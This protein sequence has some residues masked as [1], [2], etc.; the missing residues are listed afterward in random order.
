MTSIRPGIALIATL[1]L[2][3]CSTGGLDSSR[4]PYAPGPKPGALAVDGLLVGH[5]LIQAGEFEL[6]LEA[7]SRAALERGTGDVD[8]LSGLGTANL[9]LGRLGQAEQLLRRAIDT[10]NAIPETWNNLGVVLMEQGNVAEAEQVFRRAYAL[11]NGESDSIRDNL[12]LAIA[13]NKNP[14]Y[15]DKKEQDYKLVRRGSSD[16]LI[17]RVP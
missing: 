4:G 5:R 9:G 10:E 11:D 1:V 7:Y 8:V 16:Y 2:A 3:A 14:D 17:R 13:K 12:R 15:G 6:A